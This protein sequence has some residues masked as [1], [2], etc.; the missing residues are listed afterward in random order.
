MTRFQKL[1]IGAAA[2]TLLPVAVGGVVRATGSGDGCPDWPRCY[3]KFIPPFEYHALIEYS[4]RTVAA[5]SIVVLLVLAL[6]LVKSYRKVPQ[7]LWP[8]LLAFPLVMVQAYLGKLIVENGLSP[9]LVT[10]HLATAMSLAG[11]LTVL[12]VNSFFYER[13]DRVV[14]DVERELPAVSGGLFAL[15]ICAAGAAF[16][17]MLIGAYMRGVGASLVFSDWPLMDGRLLPNIGDSARAS[18]FAHRLAVLLAAGLLVWMTI[19]ILRVRPPSK[20]L[21]RLIWAAD[22]FF[23]AEAIVGAANVLARL[24][25]WARSLH[26]ILSTLTW[27]ALV[28]LAALMYQ[29]TRGHQPLRIREISQNAELDPQVQPGG[30]VEVTEVRE[31]V[32][33][34]AE[35]DGA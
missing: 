12:A 19:S 18:M 11:L 23:V 7:L 6:V 25:P 15:S 20:A 26:V 10:V 21:A 27:G 13:A 16:A 3:G 29:Y 17:V 28:A 1:A 24:A 2:V 35:I 8:G 14:E 31:P 9:T 32:A 5:V 30:A 22:A 4:H 33:A 34:G